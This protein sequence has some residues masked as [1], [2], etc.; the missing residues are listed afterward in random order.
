MVYQTKSYMLL[1]L[2]T[3]FLG[4]NSFAMDHA[5]ISKA[6]MLMPLLGFFCS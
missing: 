2:A 4:T 6:N 1:E 5:G 3:W